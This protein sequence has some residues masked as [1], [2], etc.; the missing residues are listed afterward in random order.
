MISIID[1]GA[2]NLKSVNHALNKLGFEAEIIS[3]KEKINQSTA[4]ILPGVGAFEDA[5]NQLRDLDLVDCIKDNVQAGKPIL[6]ICLGMQ[7]FYEKSYEN[8]EWEGLGL[9]EGE[10]VRFGDQ[11]KV[12]HMGW[13]NL[14]PG[15]NFDAQNGIGTGIEQKD[16]TYFVHSYYVKP[17]NRE[18]VV[19]GSD[20]GIEFP[21]VV[22]KNNIYG[23]QFHPEK[24]SEVGMT[25]LKNFGELIT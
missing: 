4:L 18:E 6:G 5:M 11:L 16:Y 20:Y 14:I 23:M 25:L 2:G 9:L 15:P 3:S 19:L 22:Q 17:K 21:A 12:P 8:G 13:N 7:L 24:S 10:V 1:Y